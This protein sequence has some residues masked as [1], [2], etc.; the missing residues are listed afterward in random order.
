MICEMCGK[1]VT[2]CKKVTIEGVQL[3]VCSECSKF[4]AEAKKAPPKELPPKPVIAQRLEVRERRGKPRDIYETSGKEELVEDYSKRIR[5][6]R[7]RTGM[8]QK[9]LA[10]KINE[11]VTILSKIEVG[12]MRPDD[13]IVSKLQKELGIVLKE[14]VAEIS[15]TKETPKPTSIT[16]ADLITMRKE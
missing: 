11:R 14:R 8:T 7:A 15:V 10:M 12:Q 13:K 2:F 1:Q 4:G 6:A 5:D 16:L 3:E 9:D